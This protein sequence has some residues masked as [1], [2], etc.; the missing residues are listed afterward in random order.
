M[1]ASV[2]VKLDQTV[3]AYLHPS[4]LLPLEMLQRPLELTLAAAVRVKNHRASIR[5]LPQRHQDSLD[6]EL[7]VLAGTHGPADDSTRVEIQHD[8]QIEPPF[9]GSDVGVG[10]DRS[11]R[12][13][14][15][16][17][18]FSGPPSEPDVRLSPHPALH[19]LFR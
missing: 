7:A 6:H 18:G 11:A 3:D 9:G 5:P 10:S 16:W 4:Q 14:S 2:G 13:I 8:G 19:M 17:V 12:P 15:R 1:N